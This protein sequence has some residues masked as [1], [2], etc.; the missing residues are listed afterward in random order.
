MNFQTLKSLDGTKTLAAVWP[1]TLTYCSGD[2]RN[3]ET[4]LLIG[5]DTLTHAIQ[6]TLN[7]NNLANDETPDL[8]ILNYYPEHDATID[9]IDEIDDGVPHMALPVTLYHEEELYKYRST[10][11][12]YRKLS[13]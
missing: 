1:T 9:H 7:V 10:D 3:L 11:E 2:T 5:L 6:H 8:A 13:R 12:E 4:E